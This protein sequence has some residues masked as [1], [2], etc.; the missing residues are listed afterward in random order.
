MGGKN[1]IIVTANA[2]L[3]E[4]VS[5]TLQSCFGH[6]GQKCSAA[7]RII[8]DARVIG[9][10]TERFMEACNNIS[11]GEAYKSSSVINPIICEHDKQRLIR[12][13]K[14]ICDEAVS[15]G[16]EVIVNRLEEALPGHCV[17][18]LV[19]LITAELAMQ[20]DSYAH[21]ELFGPIVHIIPYKTIEQAVLI[22]NSVEY[23]LTA[24]VF[25]QSQ[26][27]IDYI[28]TRLESG[29]IYV[30]RGC[31]GAR[32]GIE[33]FGGFK[34]SGTGPKTGHADYLTAFHLLLG[35]EKSCPEEKVPNDIFYAKSKGYEGGNE[36]QGG[37]G[38][39]KNINAVK[40]GLHKVFRIKES[41]I[42]FSPND[43]G[44]ESLA[45]WLEKNLSGFLSSRSY[46][47]YVPGQLSYNDYSMV[48]RSGLI[49]AS[50]KHIHINSLYNMASAVAA[51][52]SITVLARS[53]YAFDLWKRVCDCFLSSG[54]HGDR[55][56]VMIAD[57]DSLGGELKDADCSFIIIDGDERDVEELL[58]DISETNMDKLRYMRAVYTSMDGPKSSDWVEFVKQFVL[59][60]SIAINTM[61]HGAPLEINV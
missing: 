17:G 9:R 43:N 60:R 50:G 57:K 5:A 41:I 6:A 32:V 18:P 33:P 36:N 26:E 12:E 27:D 24:G 42:E 48:R 20:K 11:V 28:V 46:N 58:I 2:E 49:I 29:N 14:K 40:R 23:G 45:E 59:V 13:G 44:I 55:L 53:Q 16:G 38:I 19:L 4:T 47:N 1:P 54:V 61:R 35:K 39:N 3:D 52:S 30:N 25:S 22:A 37:L 31:T 34:H 10:F 56:H 7:S 21:K 15:N 8:V 51:G